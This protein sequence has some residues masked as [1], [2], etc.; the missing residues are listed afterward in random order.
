MKEEALLSFLSKKCNNLKNKYL[1][2]TK[3]LK[4]IELWKLF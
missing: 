4:I 3:T 1:Q 2:I